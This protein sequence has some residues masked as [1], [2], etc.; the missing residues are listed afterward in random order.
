M[1]VRFLVID[2]GLEVK[3]K[4]FAPSP[5]IAPGSGPGMGGRVPEEALEDNPQP[6][7]PAGVAIELDRIM[8]PG[9]LVSGTVRFSDGVKAT[10][11]LDQ[12][13]RLAIDAGQP[14]YKPATKDIQAFQLE[15]RREL[16]KHGF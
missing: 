11:T 6:M 2:L 10:W 7:A 15:L 4:R 12:T 13:G 1:D 3:E 9:S 8:R 14:G 5:V 16:E